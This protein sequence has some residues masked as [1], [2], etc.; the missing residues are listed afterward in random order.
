[1]ISEEACPISG[2]YVGMIPDAIGLCAKLFSDCRNPQKLFYTVSNCNN[3]SDVYQG[4]K[5]F[6]L[7]LISLNNQFCFLEREYRCLGLWNDNGLTYTYTERQDILGYECFVGVVINDAELF[8]KEAGENCQRDV[9][10]LKL[11]M[12]LSRQG[13]TSGIVVIEFQANY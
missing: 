1:M 2:E 7:T 11:G 5:T 8:I 9:E 3:N 6:N 13:I 4:I 10:P 12:K